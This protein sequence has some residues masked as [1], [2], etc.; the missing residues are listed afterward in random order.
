MDGAADVPEHPPEVREQALSHLGALY[1]FALYLAKRPADAED[2]VQETYL[3]AFRFAHRF[4][5]GTH[6]RAWLFQILRNTFLTFYRRDSRELTVLNKEGADGPDEVWDAEAPVA[7]AATNR[8]DHGHPGRH[9][10]VAAVSRPTAGPPAALRLPGRL[11]GGGYG[12]PRRARG[13]GGVPAGR[14]VRRRG[15]PRGGAP[16]ALPLVSAA[17]RGRERA[18]DDDPGAAAKPGSGC[19]HPGSEPARAP[20]AR[21]AQL[22]RPAVGGRRRGGRG[23]GGGAGAVGP[24]PWPTRGRSHRPVAPERGGGARADAASASGHGGRGA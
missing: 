7:S 22:D 17:P 2:L 20:A 5:P 14:A 8:A 11:T 12:L 6:L 18:G 10:E 21:W 15:R 19:P 16:L 4:Q 3:R 13:P 1:N 23:R 9:R 24:V